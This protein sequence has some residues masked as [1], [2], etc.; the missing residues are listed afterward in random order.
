M[1]L[2]LVPIAIGVGLIL[3]ELRKNARAARDA[4]YADD[5]QAAIRRAGGTR[6][7]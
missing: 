3:H 2:L 1:S 6:R 7:W 5:R 4:A